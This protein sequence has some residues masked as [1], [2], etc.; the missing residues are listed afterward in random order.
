MKLFEKLLG[1]VKKKEKCQTES[2]FLHHYFVGRE[3]GKGAFAIVKE[4]TRKSD[5]KKFAAKI[6]D[7]SKAKDEEEAIQTEIEVLKQLHHPH[8]VGLVELFQTSKHYYLIMELATGG[9]LFERILEKGYYT[10]KDA[11]TLVKQLLLALIYIHDD[12]GI[13]HR[14]LKPENLLFENRSEHSSLLLTDFGLSRILQKNDF[15]STSCGTPHYVAPEILKESGHSFPVDM[16][17]C[18]VITYVLLCGYTPFWGG[19]HNDMNVL[20]NSIMRGKF[21]FEEEFW[22]VVSSTAKDF[23][24]KLLVVDPARRL[25]AKQ[26]YA[27]PWLL[28]DLKVDLLPNVRKNFNA[29]TTLK[30]A[31]R[32]IQLIN[33]LSSSVASLANGGESS[34]STP[35][36]DLVASPKQ[37]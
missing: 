35:H 24:C 34:E 14:D 4:V 15:L 12:V 10:E 29:R 20:Y 13:V 37:T 25:T 7:K 28:N 33:R 18:G 36:G 22:G 26:A 2:D 27:H 5:G 21:D 9:E 8:I 17:A 6:I 31:V 3:L 11:A 16:W 32:A 19:E 1:G 30:K 23:I